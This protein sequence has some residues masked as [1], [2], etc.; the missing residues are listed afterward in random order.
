MALM[1]VALNPE[2]DDSL[3]VPFL[4]RD[5]R[6][7]DQAAL[8]KPGAKQENEPLEVRGTVDALVQ[9][10]RPDGRPAPNML[11]ACTDDEARAMCALAEKLG[12]LDDAGQAGTSGT[13]GSAGAPAFDCLDRAGL[14]QL[15]L[16]VSQLGRD[17]D[18]DSGRLHRPSSTGGASSSILMEAGPRASSDGTKISSAAPAVA[19]EDTQST[20]KGPV[21]ELP[22][23]SCGDYVHPYLQRLLEQPATAYVLNPSGGSGSLFDAGPSDDEED[24]G[25]D[26]PRARG[27]G[28]GRGRGSH[29]SLSREALSAKTPAATRAALKAQGNLQQDNRVSPLPGV[30]DPTGS[31]LADPASEL[32]QL[33]LMSQEQQQQLADAAA[34]SGGAGGGMLAATPT[35]GGH[36]F[37]VEKGSTGPAGLRG[38]RARNSV[39]YSALAGK[40]DKERELR[41]REKEDRERAKSAAPKY[42]RKPGPK[43]GA[44]W[45]AGGPGS[46]GG[47][48]A[49]VAINPLGL[50]SKAPLLFKDDPTSNATAAAV[51]AVIADGGP[52]G[53]LEEQWSLLDAAS[54]V[55]SMA[56]DDEVLAELL[57]LQS[58]LVQQVAIN[59]A[60]A[61]AVL[62]AVVADIPNQRAV[63]AQRAEWEDLIRNYLQR[64]AEAKRNAKREKRENE[65]RQ[66]LAALNEP[67]SPRPFAGRPKKFAGMPLGPFDGMGMPLGAEG[68]EGAEGW[69]GETPGLSAGEGVAMEPLPMDDAN[70]VDPLA[71]RAQDEEALCAV[72]GDGTSVDPNMIV[73]CERCDIAVHQLCYGVRSIPADEWLCWPCRFYEDQQRAQ[74]VPQNEIRPKRWEMEARG[75]TH[76]ELPGGS[77]AVSCCLCPVRMGAFKRTTD[78][79]KW[80]HVVCSMWHEGPVVHPFDGPDAIDNLGQIKADR[81]RSPCALCGKVAGAVVKCNFGHC[82]AYFHPLCGRRAGNYLCARMQPGARTLRY[83][84]YCHNHSNAQR[85]KDMATGAARVSDVMPVLASSGKPG[86]RG[87]SAASMSAELSA[88]DMGVA[89]FEGAAGVG[90]MD[91]AFGAPEMQQFG[92]PDSA[93]A[94]AAAA[95]G[96]PG[97][98]PKRR[99]GRPPKSA[100]QQNLLQL[101]LAPNPPCLVGPPPELHPGMPLPS[102]AV[103]E[104]GAASLQGLQMPPSQD[105]GAAG[106]GLAGAMSG[107]PSTLST[108]PSALPSGISAVSA[109]KP[110]LP[111]SRL[112][113][114]AAARR[115]AAAA[116][117]AAGFPGAVDGGGTGLGPVPGGLGAAEQQQSQQPLLGGIKTEG[118]L[119]AKGPGRATPSSSQQQGASDGGDTAAT[120][121]KP[122]GLA[123]GVGGGAKGAMASAKPAAGRGRQSSTSAGAMA[124]AGTGGATAS[125]GPKRAKTGVKEEPAEGEPGALGPGISPEAAAAAS[126]AAAKARA[127][128]TAAA[129]RTRGASASGRTPTTLERLAHLEHQ[130]SMMGRW[131]PNSVRNE[132]E[133]LR[134]VADTVKVRRRERCKRQQYRLIRDALAAQGT[135]PEALLSFFENWEWPSADNPSPFAGDDNIAAPLETALDRFLSGIKGAAAPGAA[136]QGQDQGQ[137]AGQGADA[138]EVGS[139][140]EHPGSTGTKRARTTPAGPPKKPAKDIMSGRDWRKRVVMGPDGKWVPRTGVK[141]ASGAS[142][143]GGP[144]GG[145]GSAGA[146]GGS[147]ADADAADAQPKA[148]TAAAVDPKEARDGD[149]EVFEDAVERFAEGQPGEGKGGDEQMEEAGAHPGEHGDRNQVS[150]SGGPDAGAEEVT[151]AGGGAAAAGPAAEGATGE[152]GRGTADSGARDVEMRDAQHADGAQREAQAADGAAISGGEGDGSNGAPGRDAK[153]EAASEEETVTVSQDDAAESAEVEG[154]QQAQSEA[155]QA[156]A[157]DQAAE[158]A[159]GSQETSTSD[160]API[161]QLSRPVGM[162]RARRAV[163]SQSTADA[164]NAQLPKGYRFE[165]ET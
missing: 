99:Y 121:P 110:P 141:V 66:A 109:G 86:R 27:G 87:G 91:T 112:S 151:G 165:K 38:G 97:G 149:D 26:I 20:S 102:P 68:M 50:L 6:G 21:H 44:S 134:T 103:P 13:A 139:H 58:E 89:A 124:A 137:A 105:V 45:G 164:V 4:G 47:M 129:V 22:R 94:A 154:G 73:F 130:K 74:G 67:A 75:I 49:P 39:N 136:G 148:G 53:P 80:A 51:H 122:G 60:R 33:A 79:T 18:G 63:N 152:A 111:G 127:A 7:A 132:L 108:P 153:P 114:T 83:R 159:V 85:D 30:F 135:Q 82:Q 146:G 34:A 131:G 118:G 57:A 156:E 84:A 104:G 1:P 14:D 19:E 62:E 100:K 8:A 113:L 37:P 96:C 125:S 145:D 101:Q 78:S 55:M 155:T 147:A 71:V 98:I 17:G 16:K 162:P 69:R 150:S 161:A 23:A 76:A 11:D 107:F 52:E 158:Q 64:K 42:K 70:L 120:G 9:G 81:F 10:W 46:L 54:D 28:R 43:A 29:A 160:D 31:Q 138:A 15:L 48:R 32:T 142:P 5:P 144:D 95:A 24:A 119:K 157:A 123:L 163:M 128:A 116:A 41:E 93:A 90:S 61:A 59:R 36:A 133:L 88:A 92:E 65:R 117:A 12:L 40:K 143:R 126:A 3:T 140:E 2:E 106:M 56:P 35:F 25:A 72:C 77:H 115:K